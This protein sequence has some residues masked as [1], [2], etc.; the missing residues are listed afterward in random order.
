MLK[1]KACSFDFPFLYKPNRGGGLMMRD[2][3]CYY[4]GCRKVAVADG[5]CLRHLNLWI[6]N[7]DKYKH[8]QTL[9]QRFLALCLET[10]KG[11]LL[12]LKRH[13]R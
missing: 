4:E 12:A 7:V 5:L 13:I 9:A 3:L 1:L 11:R 2:V 8:N 6:G 10:Y